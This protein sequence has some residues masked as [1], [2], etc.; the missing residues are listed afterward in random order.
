MGLISRSLASLPRNGR[1]FSTCIGVQLR[2]FNEPL[3]G[4]KM[5][6]AGGIASMMRLPI[7]ETADGGEHVVRDKTRDLDNDP[8]I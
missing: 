7:Q 6:R 3:S 2:Q 5:A 1:F 8:F 4:H